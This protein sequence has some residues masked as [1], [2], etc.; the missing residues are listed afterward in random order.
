MLEVQRNMM[1]SQ[2]KKRG[3]NNKD[4]GFS[5]IF[6]ASNVHLRQGAESPGV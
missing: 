2:E 6:I 4:H 1:L 5:F 3:A